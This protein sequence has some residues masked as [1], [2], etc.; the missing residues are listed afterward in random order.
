MSG[1]IENRLIEADAHDYFNQLLADSKVRRQASL[2]EANTAT[3]RTTKLS[4][5][6]KQILA[7]ALS[8]RGKDHADVYANDIKVEVFGWQPLSHYWDGWVNEGR[9]APGTARYAQDH[10][11]ADKVILG[12]IFDRQSIGYK[13]YNSIS[14]S[15]FRAIK[16]LVVRH[17]L[18]Q[19][20]YGW[21][22]T[23][24]GLKVVKTCS[25]P[26]QS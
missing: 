22:L 23:D 4:P 8:W 25:P 3:P 7:I 26:T 16:R 20:S 19:F 15:I 1:Q 14:V 21:S 12:R 18:Y 9:A 2:D 24:H 11:L 10:H 5:L 13:R 6:Q 17:L